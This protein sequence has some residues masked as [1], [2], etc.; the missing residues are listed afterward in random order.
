[1]GLWDKIRGE[2]IDIVEWIDSTRDTMVFRFE[3]HGN[4][5]KQGAKLV[6][7]EGQAA[8]FINEGRLADVFTPGTYTLETKNLPILSTLQGWKYGFSSPFKAEVYFVSMRLFTDLKWGT[9]NPIMLRDPEFGPARIRAFGT[10]V[11]QVKDPGVFIQ[12][13]V[14]TEGAFTTDY[15]TEQLRNF[16]V[17]RFADLLG[18]SKIPILDMSGN[19]DELGKFIT[20][21]LE[22]E[23]GDYGLNL[24]KLLI[25]N[26]SLP[27]EVE[28]A[29]DR[30]TSMGVVGNL[31]AYAKFQTANSIPDAAKNP[32]GLAAGGVGL[33][34][35][36]TMA[37]QM[38]QALSPQ[39]PSSPPPI[40]GA[41]EFFVAQAGKQTGPF[42][43]DV[44]SGDARSGKLTRESL[45]WRQ[46]MAGWM[47]AAKVAELGGLFPPAPPPLPP[48]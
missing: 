47:P 29:L 45:V 40:P 21:R 1:M 12:K 41:V 13:I 18:E 38:A 43:L 33:G 44:L 15:V 11:I 7:R 35:G 2:F 30:R 22:P 27:P 25:E 23:F 34:M 6:V 37:G 28:A 46:G 4:E 3:R 14:G 48:A 32:G 8:A 16:I 24:Q 19:Y 5:I 36:F 31:D 20:G 26:I 42:G 17:S 9:K 39:T 10:Y